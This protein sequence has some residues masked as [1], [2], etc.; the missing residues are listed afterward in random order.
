MDVEEIKKVFPYGEL[1][2]IEFQSGGMR[3]SSGIALP[4]MGG[5]SETTTTVGA[6]A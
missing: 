4:E 5:G 6:V 2:P 3:A 1:L